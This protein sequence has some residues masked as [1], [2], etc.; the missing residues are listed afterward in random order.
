[1]ERTTITHSGAAPRSL[2]ERQRDER[3]A[4][5]LDAAQ[6]IFTEKGFHDAS[7]DEIATRVGISRGRSICISRVKTPSSRRGRARRCPVSRNG[8]RRHRRSD[9]VRARLE[10]IL[11][12]AYRGLRDEGGHVALELN[13]GFGLASGVI[14]QRP[15]LKAHVARA[16]ERIAALFEEGKRTGELDPTVPTPIM[17]ATFGSLLSPHRYAQLLTSDQFSTAELVM[18]VSHLFFRGLLAPSPPKED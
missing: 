2:K 17:V 14:E 15:A 6:E 1:M 7:I 18:H 13:S 8:R 3:T 10:Q 16:T 5:L 11:E 4:L 9:T 12:R